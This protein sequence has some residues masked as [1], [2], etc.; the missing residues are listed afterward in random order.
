MTKGST[1][2]SK[3]MRFDTDNTK[4]SQEIPQIKE[5]EDKGGIAYLLMVLFG[6]GALLPWNAILTALDF[7]KEK[8]PG[9]QPDFVFSLANNGLLTVIQLF[10]VIQGHKYGYVLRISGGFLVIS[11]LMIGLPLSA[12]FLNPDAGFAA[13]ISILVVFGAMGGIVQGSVFGLAG[14]F[15]F[16][17]MGAVMFGNGLSGI[18]LNILRAIT[19]AALPP[20][21]GSDNNFKGSLIYFILAS[22]ILI[23]C[24][25]GMVFFM[26]MNFVIYYVKKASDEKNKTVRRISGIREDMDEADRSLL[27]SADINKTADLSQKNL[28][29]DHNSHVQQP[30]HSAF[31]AF[32]IMLKRSF[33]YAWQFLTAITSVFVITFVVFPGVSLHTGLAFMSGITDPGLR[34]AWTALIFIILFNVFDTIGR[35]LAGQSF[36]QA[37]DK[38]VIILVYSRAIFIVTFVL[39]S[40]DQPPM[41][42]FGDNA[43][44]FKVINMILFAFSNGYCSTQCAIKAPSRAP[45]DSKEQVGTLIGLFLTIGIFLGSLIALGMGKMFHDQ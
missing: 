38:L 14:M 39:I 31:V 6:I 20:I 15:P 8:L 23:I 42:L 11:V 34:G 43:D 2:E 4:Y 16:K 18:T 21:T 17:Y 22:V 40:L 25:I 7:F 13:C 1:L 37:P 36:G 3:D 29:V 12:N 24:A 9:Y 19:L 30:T 41:W 10:I 35:W 44:W 33:I 45:D 26:K 28:K 5:P 32:M 27:S